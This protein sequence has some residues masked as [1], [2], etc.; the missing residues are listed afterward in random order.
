MNKK[1]TPTHKPQSQRKAKLFRNPALQLAQLHQGWLDPADQDW[2]QRWDFP[3]GSMNEIL[4][5]LTSDSLTPL[6]IFQK[7]NH[8]PNTKCTPVQDTY[9]NQLVHRRKAEESLIF[10]GNLAML[11]NCANFLF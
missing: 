5:L 6:S 2:K 10:R 7:E 8:A 3:Q 4:E 11:F 9:K 1:L